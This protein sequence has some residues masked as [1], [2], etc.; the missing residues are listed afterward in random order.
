MEQSNIQMTDAD[1]KVLERLNEIVAKYQPLEPTRD[2]VRQAIIDTASAFEGIQEI[3][4]SNTGYWINIFH[5]V[6]GLQPGYPWC[7][8]YV[9]YVY[10]F[11]SQIWR[12]RDILPYNR[13][14]VR[15]MWNW[16]KREEFVETQPASAKFADILILLDGNEPTGHTEILTA[17]DDV[18]MCTIG[19]NTNDATSR[20]GGRVARH[21]M[22][23]KKYGPWGEPRTAKRWV[24][25]V[26]SFDKLYAKFW[27]NADATA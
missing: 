1:E 13:A 24:A 17:I 20:D 8:M 22:P 9:Q 7:M 25:G 16:A 23:I 18:V 11:V 19:G 26:I 5:Q 3:G 4:T 6:L 21:T 15:V 14:G 27:G 10:W 2:V 12:N